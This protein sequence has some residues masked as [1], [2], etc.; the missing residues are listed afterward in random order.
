MSQQTR[1]VIVAFARLQA[2]FSNSMNFR[3]IESDVFKI[4]TWI[5]V[6][7]KC[8]LFCYFSVKYTFRYRLKRKLMMFNSFHPLGHHFKHI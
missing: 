3:K 5:S 1:D 8:L 6:K 2:T 4:T 7:P